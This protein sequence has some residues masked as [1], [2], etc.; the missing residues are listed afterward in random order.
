MEE[1]GNQ[2][3]SLD[4]RGGSLCLDFANTV[5][6]HTSDAPEERL[7]G[8]D[9]LVAWSEQAGILGESESARMLATA[10]SLPAEADAAL[11]R[12]TE[13][14]E[15]LFRIFSAV[16]ADQPPSERDLGI[17]NSV[18]SPALAHLRVARD[19][20]S[21][22]WRWRQSGELDQMLWPVA[23]SAAE[24]LVSDRLDRVKMCAGDS[25]G[26]LFVDTSRNRSRRWCDMS[27]CG[28]RAKARRHY[29]RTR[30][31]AP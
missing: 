16:A 10:R 28:N 7:A 1:S 17:L 25:C 2:A 11:R 3:V 6:W 30:V 4:L 18:L 22:G 29:H 5:G 19:A 27:D 26:W 12:A 8:Y 14:R 9:D 13:F 23:R 15:A 24:L 31:A 20:G 21:Y